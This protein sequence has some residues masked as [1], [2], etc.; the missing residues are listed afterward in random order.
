MGIFYSLSSF[1][2]SIKHVLCN[3]KNEDV[4]L[5]KNTHTHTHKTKTKQNQWKSISFYARPNYKV[6]N[7]FCI[8]LYT[9]ILAILDFKVKKVCILS[10]LDMKQ[11]YILCL[12]IHRCLCNNF[13]IFIF[14]KLSTCYMYTFDNLR[15]PGTWICVLIAY[16]Y[17]LPSILM[18]H[19]FGVGAHRFFLTSIPSFNTSQLQ[20]PTNTHKKEICSGRDQNGYTKL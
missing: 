6:Y 10:G 5:K 4:C 1:A 20:S 15:L 12:F 14:C 2:V 18:C 7:K 8:R 17:L 16:T 11:Y 9:E 13:S 3:L 19:L